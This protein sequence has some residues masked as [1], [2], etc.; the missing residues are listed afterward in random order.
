MAQAV[1]LFID[2]RV[3]LDIGIRVGDIRFRLIIIVIGN[4]IFHRVIREKLTELRTE[5]GGEGLIMSQH[6]RR[7]VQFFDNGRHGKGLA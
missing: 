2:G 6:Q 7:S 1:D 3:F 5:L 4:K